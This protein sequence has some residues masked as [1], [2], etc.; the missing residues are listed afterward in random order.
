MTPLCAKRLS[1]RSSNIHRLY[2]CRN[3]TVSICGICRTRNAMRNRS[4][5]Q[6]DDE[7]CEVPID[8]LRQ[9][10]SRTGGF[11]GNRPP[12]FFEVWSAAVLKSFHS[13]AIDRS[14]NYRSAGGLG[15][16]SGFAQIDCPYRT[17]GTHRSTEVHKPQG[18]FPS[19]AYDGR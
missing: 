12:A 2:S 10:G 7:A 6:F 16:G 4:D 14:T 19:P 1:V 17:R 11:R 5:R 8:F 15:H 13:A 9:N 18:V 3:P